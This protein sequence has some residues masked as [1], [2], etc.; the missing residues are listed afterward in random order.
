MAEEVPEKKKAK[1]DI[2]SQILDMMKKRKQEPAVDDDDD[3]KFLLSFRSDMKTMAKSQKLDF[4]L[5][6]LQLVKTITFPPPP[7]QVYSSLSS[8]SY[9]QSP[10]M[11]FTPSPSSNQEIHTTGPV[12]SYH[13]QSPL[14]PPDHSQHSLS[15][16]ADNAV[17]Y[18][19]LQFNK[20]N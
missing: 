2:P 17:V 11:I 18:E 5:G 12:P 14:S 3:T 1:K 16:H 10:Q 8:H 20:N 13:Q 19:F 4:K 9:T 6:M 7:R 15:G